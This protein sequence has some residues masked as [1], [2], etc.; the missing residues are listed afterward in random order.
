[1]L[2]STYEYVP[3][4]TSKHHLFLFDDDKEKKQVTTMK[5]KNVNNI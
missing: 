2:T 5:N 3:I 1:L 4:K